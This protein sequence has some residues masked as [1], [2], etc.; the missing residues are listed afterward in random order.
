VTQLT[1]DQRPQGWSDGAAGYESSFAPLTDL[2]ASDAIRLLD[3]KPG[4]RFLDVCAGTGALALPAARHGAEVTAVDF[5]AGMVALLRERMQSA[6]FNAR[7]EEMDGQALDLPD[8]YFDAAASMFGLI[9]FP[10]LN[11]GMSELARVTKPGGRVLVAAWDR[12]RSPLFE[13]M[14]R[15]LAP[16]SP[17]PPDRSAVPVS[18][19]IGERGALAAA[20]ESAGLVDVEVNELTHNWK[21]A[22]PAEFFASL[23]DWSPPMQPVFAALPPQVLER[24]RAGFVKAVGDLSR[25]TGGLET[26]AFLAL[27]RRAST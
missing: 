19:R 6:G 10:D 23:P 11:A 2:Y 14:F 25:P 22:D 17:T 13:A 18:M 4:D 7:V 1:H 16:L 20:C 3:L 24:A 9:F 15:A 5:A 8:S 12:A 21:M 26:T 27:G